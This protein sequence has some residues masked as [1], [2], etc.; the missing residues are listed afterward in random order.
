MNNLSGDSQAE[1]TASRAT[2][3]PAVPAWG[4]RDAVLLILLGLLA[5]ALWVP[6]LEGPID[7]RYDS[8]VYYLLG[9]SIAQGKGYRILSE[10]G[11]PVGVQYPPALPAF[12]AVHQWVLGTDDPITVGSALRIS[13]CVLSVFYT[14]AVYVMARQWIGP[15]ASGLGSLLCTMY[16]GSYYYSDMLFTDVPCGLAAVL[17]VIC[18][19]WASPLG[20]GVTTTALAWLAFLLRT[21]G[22][23][24]LAAWVGEA[25]L[26]RQWKSAGIRAGLA[27]V[28]FVLWQGHVML[29]ERSEAY[30]NP[31]YEYQRADYMFYNVS[32]ANNAK[33]IDPFQPELGYASN[34]ELLSRVSTNLLTMPTGL[35]ESASGPIRILGLSNNVLHKF[36]GRRVPEPLLY[37]MILLATG[38]IMLGVVRLARQQQWVI[39]LYVMASI[40]LICLTPWPGQFSRYLTPVTPLLTVLLAI[41]ASW[42]W[43]CARDSS[44]WYLSYPVY[45]V[46]GVTA[47]SI[48]ASQFAAAAAMYKWQTERVSV[49]YR[50][51]EVNTQRFYYGQ[52]WHSFEKI[53]AWIGEHAGP[54]DLVATASPHKLYLSTGVKSIMPPF[55]ADPVKADRQ[56]RE[57]GVTYIV[58]DDFGFVDISPRYAKPAIEQH[59]EHWELVYTVP[60][61]DMQ[62]YRR[63]DPATSNQLEQEGASHE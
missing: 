24:L 4:R 39:P 1:P 10:P 56:L 62:V 31:A 3:R 18:L 6:R 11:E 13:F 63:V 60:A 49:I 43:S 61:K 28:P 17:F 40:A 41:G 38:L 59:S 36:T 50:G 45:T 23:A 46:V 16:F 44:R 47:I 21:A 35:G 25:L 42:L 57:A 2:P 19:R 58:L 30:Q 27:A 26:R 9:T 29:T 7:L 15:L 12:V 51:R 37:A 22:I 52:D 55:E 48:V 14:L 54:E 20:R 8:G 33:L 32:Y 5:F 53:V 34:A